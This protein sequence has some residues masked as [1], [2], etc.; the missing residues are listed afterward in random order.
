MRRI[1]LL[2]FFL[3]LRAAAQQPSTVQGIVV[4]ALTNNPI[5]RASIELRDLGGDANPVTRP[6]GVDPITAGYPGLTSENGQF[7]LRNIPPGR[8]SLVASHTGYVHG[9]YGQHGPNG[10]ALVL[11][12]PSGQSISGIR[13]VMMPNAAI[14]GHAYDSK[15]APLAYVQMQA[16]RVTYPDGQFT[17]TMTSSTVTDD[18]G[19]YRLYGLPPGQYVLSAE[20]YTNSVGITPVTVSQTPPVPGV[21]MSASA[22]G[23]MLTDT[24]PANQNRRKF[25]IGLIVFYP[26]AIDPVDAKLMD[27][28]AG[29]DVKGINVTL[30]SVRSVVVGGTGTITRGPSNAD[31]T[32]DVLFIMNATQSVRNRMAFPGGGGR[33]NPTPLPGA[34]SFAFPPGGYLAVAMVHATGNELSSGAY[35]YFNVGLTP[36]NI[37]LAL[38]PTQKISGH[39][40]IEGRSPGS[41]PDISKL[42]INFRR[43]PIIPSANQQSTAAVKNDGS[44]SSGGVLDGD[45]AFSITGFPD[46]LRNAYVKSVRGANVEIVGDS[47]RLAA[48]PSG[49]MDVNIVLGVNGGQISGAAVSNSSESLSNVTVLL[50]PDVVD[51]RDLYRSTV[52]D[53]VGKYSFDQLPPGDYRLFSWEDV[54]PDVWFNPAF[55]SSLRDLGKT[56]RIVEGT[57][58]EINVTAIPMR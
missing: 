19:A 57:R 30:D 26:S 37:N 55:M 20:T 38:A 53:A 45:Y 52:T 47:V 41:E 58:S 50:V 7:V 42:R 23:P 21:V 25:D 1:T 22:H 16:R 13:L 17:M 29:E 28:R 35:Q 36:A 24:D 3:T 43:I 11:T 6:G 12:V 31:S 34:F 27:V 51:R 2:L 39:V 56:V 18:L 33:G 4:D 44:F 54:E 48:Q 8:Y 10:K 15:G 9:E 5:A 46:S 40:S 14:A 32:V 49:S